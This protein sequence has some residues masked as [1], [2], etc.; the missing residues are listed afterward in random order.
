MSLIRGTSL[1]GFPEL[2]TE[3]GGD[4]EA[5]LAAAHV[6][7]DAV[8]N[9]DSFISTRSVIT[10]VESAADLTRAPD[11]G[12]QL[13]LRQ[14]LEIL[15]PVGVAVRTAPTVGSALQ[16]AE[17]YMSVYSPALS[18]AIDLRPDE[19]HARFVWRLLDDRIPSHRQVAEL[20]LGIAMQVFRLLVGPGFRP[21]AVHLPHEQ[22]ASTRDYVRY[23]GCPAHFSS[24]Y[25]GFVLRRSDLSRPLSS[26][27]A[28]HEVVRGYLSSIAP[29]AGG[30]T[31]EPVR[32][33]IRRMLLTGGLDIELVAGHLAVHPRT[34]QRQLA[35]QGTSFA[36]LLDEVRRSETERY[37]VE[38][39][40][41]LGQLAG[42]LGYSEQ[43]VLSRSCQRWFGMSASAYRRRR[44]SQLS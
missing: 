18:T 16:A 14:G 35:R 22:L 20:G 39:D 29:P 12:R 26:D 13:A 4:P 32:L 27:S 30:G 37:L 2:V 38:T 41:S 44:T 6:P 10:A 43:S 15:G 8:G 36:G 34:L 5:L 42:I 11:F 28:V 31:V 25:A 40:V 19:Q 23:F 9:Q 7:R 17:Q 21:V 24:T 33:L 1:Q 3:L